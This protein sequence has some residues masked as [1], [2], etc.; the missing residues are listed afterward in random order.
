MKLLTLRLHPFGAAVDRSCTLQDGLNVLEGPNEFGK[1]TLSNALWHTLQTPTNLTPAK[2][3]NTIGRWY[4]MPSGDHVRVT[5]CFEA[6]GSTWTLEKTWGAGSASRLHADSAAAIADP[7]KVQ[8]KLNALLRL[9]EATWRQVLFTGQAQLAATVQE[10]AAN[11][12]ALDDVHTLLKGAAAIP[13]DIAPEKLSSA[14]DE[15]TEAHFSRWDV[16]TNGPEAGRGITN[17]WRNKL[18]PI[19]EAYYAKEALRAQHDNVVRYEHEL[20]AVNARLGEGQEALKKDEAFIRE[21]KGLRQG[22]S[23]R[24]ALEE[25]VSRLTNEE[26]ALMAIVAAWPGADNVIEAKDKEHTRH[27]NSLTRLETELADAR[28]HAAAEA[29]RQG[30]LRLTAAKVAWDEANQKLTNTRAVDLLALKKLKQLEQQIEALRIQIAA[31]K[32]AAKLEASGER[33]VTLQRGAEA[34]ESIVLGPSK[35]WEGEAAGRFT[36]EVDDLR[37]SVQSGM[38]DVDALFTK[39]TAANGKHSEWLAAIG[40]ENLAA[41]ET[42]SKANEDLA[43]DAK[44]KEGLYTAALQGR[45]AEQWAADMEAIATLPQT[46]A[47]PVLEQEKTETLA[48]QATLKA[49]ADQERRKV[50]QWV[51]EHTDISTLMQKVID[52]KGELQ[53]AEQE[54]SALPVLP[55]GFGSVTDYLNMLETKEQA[56]TH[57]QVRLQAEQV[58]H[59]ELMG[60]TPE[61]TAEDIRSELDLKEREFRRQLAE[62]ECLL[63]IREK[64]K[65]MITARGDGDPLQGLTEAIATHFNALTGGR[66]TG[67]QLDGPAPAQVNGAASLPIGLLSQGTLG[68]LALATRLALAQLYLKEDNGFLVM[69]DPFTDMDP[70][71]RSA[72]IR[73]IGEFAQEKQVLLFTCHPQHAQEAR[74]LVGANSV[75]IA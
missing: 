1:S 69:D 51:R 65:A 37:I 12:A 67:V 16:Q 71:R 28:K 72:A 48:Q 68:S 34:S 15:R 27:G 36:V 2:L 45:T 5:L 39:L 75:A 58:K 33:T 66:Y 59:A 13:G 32:L 44:T 8:E 26:K 47:L 42:A 43:R 23:K 22:L 31:Q 4:P 53:T 17:P 41:A 61:R 6:Q 30:H 25:K 64:L 18:G 56:Q 3:R 35:P 24:G 57:L 62:G 29:L 11:G 73:A 60:R 55:K 52:R 54:L 46:R 49:E 74:E 40:H 20:D 21:G 19:V 63:R 50:E 38:E 10:L 14:L 7:E 70:G 9:N